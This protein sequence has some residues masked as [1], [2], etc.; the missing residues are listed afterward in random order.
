M[1]RKQCKECGLL[2]PLHK[3]PKLVNNKLKRDDTC[4]DC[5]NKQAFRQRQ[6]VKFN[7]IVKE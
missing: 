7:Q 4:L 6:Q 2:K 1:E 5:I 3:F